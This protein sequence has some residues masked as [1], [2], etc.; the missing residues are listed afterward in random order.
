MKILVNKTEVEVPQ[1]LINKFYKDFDGLPGGKHYDSVTDLRDS[2]ENILGL[3]DLNP[4]VIN[5]PIFR[6]DYIRAIAMM[7]A[8]KKHGI[9]YDA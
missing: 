5:D 1:M 8:L 4:S 7:H 3:V 2:I 9:Y 6:I